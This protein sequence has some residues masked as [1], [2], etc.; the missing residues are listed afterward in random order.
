MAD[1][2][3]MIKGSNAAGRR[4]DIVAAS[5]ERRSLNSPHRQPAGGQGPGHRREAGADLGLSMRLRNGGPEPC[6]SVSR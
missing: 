3:D 4:R 2:L 1:Y 6:R 5:P